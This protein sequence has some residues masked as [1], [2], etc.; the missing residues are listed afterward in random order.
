MA[1]VRIFNALSNIK[2]TIKEYE[3]F[4]LPLIEVSLER[5]IRYYILTIILLGIGIQII[6]QKKEDQL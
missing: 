2:K 5:H 1:E 3:S 6:W 4:N